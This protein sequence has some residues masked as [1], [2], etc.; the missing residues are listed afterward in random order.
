MKIPVAVFLLPVLAT[1]MTCRDAKPKAASAP[2]RTLTPW[3]DALATG[4]VT[5]LADGSAYLVGY[6]GLYFIS[7]GVSSRVTG[8]PAGTFTGVVPLAD[9]SALVSDQLADA[10]ALYWLRGSEATLVSEGEAKRPSAVPASAGAFHFVHAQL[11][12]SRLRDCEARVQ[13]LE[14]SAPVDLEPE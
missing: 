5:P 9:G 4:G 11:A 8:L 14:E 6:E 13:E 10:P 12:E 2:K 3:Q 1:V 7:Q